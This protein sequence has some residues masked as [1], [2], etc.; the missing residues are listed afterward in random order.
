MTKR[1][2]P[3]IVNS[4]LYDDT[5]RTTL[6]EEECLDEIYK[7]VKEDPIESWIMQTSPW[8]DHEYSTVD[9]YYGDIIRCY[10]YVNQTD[11]AL[12]VNDMHLYKYA[13][14]TVGFY[15]FLHT[16]IPKINKI[17]QIVILF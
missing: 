5:E 10:A 3:I 16:L 9:P 14:F 8:S 1:P 2:K 4:S 12:R 7:F 11:R 17:H 13:N 6:D 15:N